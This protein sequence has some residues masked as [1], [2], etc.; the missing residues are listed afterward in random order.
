MKKSIYLFALLLSASFVF[1]A[2][3]RDEPVTSVSLD[4]STLILAV[5]E[6]QRLIATILPA[7][8]TNQNIRWTSDSEDVA[9]IDNNGLVTAISVGVATITVTTVCG[10]KTATSVVTVTLP[11]NQID[12]GVEINGIRWATR[13]VDA[14][15]TFAKNPEDA[16][17]F[18]QFN[19]NIGWSSADPMINTNGGTTWDTSVVPIGA[20]WARENDPC[21]A[22]WRVPTE[23][24]IMENLRTQPN[25]W[26]QINGVSGRLLGTA[27]NQIF[28]PAAGMRELNV[29]ALTRVGMRGYYWSADNTTDDWSMWNLGLFTDGAFRQHALPH[30]SAYSVRCV[31]ED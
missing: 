20:T 10:G 11:A 5:G 21:P 7:D 30:A 23:I 27:P 18:Y 2:C 4:H 12:V 8:A 6:N 19:R 16:G 28:L 17:M 25:T 1:T 9:I 29:G 14:P 15:G 31:A 26:T 22:G 24:E 3:D 13:N